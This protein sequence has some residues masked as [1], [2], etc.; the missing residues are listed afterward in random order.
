MF[1][2]A[3]FK[4]DLQPKPDIAYQAW[5]SAGQ[6]AAARRDLNERTAG[7]VPSFGSMVHRTALAA[8]DSQSY[9]PGKV[10]SIDEKR[11]DI[12]YETTK[13]EDEYSFGD[14]I[15]MINPLQHLPVVGM[16]YRK[17]TGDTIK[18]M[19]NIIGGAIFG[20]PVGA[21][22]STV[23]AIVQNRTGKDIAENAFSM[24]G[25]DIAPSP[26]APEIIYESANE[27]IPHPTSEDDY[28]A[29][30]TSYERTSSGQRNF[31]AH[32]KVIYSWNA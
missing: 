15:D 32:N 1:E 22:S 31:A 23:N 20:G 30:A 11:P 13:A 21:I 6:K 19:S 9:A 27:S 25:I 8:Q 17:L 24:V 26:P 16:I 5:Q 28:L 18:P 2:P 29:A 10:T 4:T 12:A 14:V 7:P 3:F